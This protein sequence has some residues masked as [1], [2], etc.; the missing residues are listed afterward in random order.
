MTDQDALEEI[1]KHGDILERHMYSHGAFAT[2]FSIYPI[3]WATY[4]L[5][6]RR[7]ASLA[8]TS[9]EWQRF[10]EF[11]YTAIVRC[12]NT[13]RTVNRFSDTSASNISEFDP[14][15]AQLD[16]HDAFACFFYFVGAAVDNL[17]QA[18]AS[19]PVRCNTAF[20]SIFG[21]AVHS[22]RN[23]DWFFKRRH[24]FI[25]KALVPCVEESELISVDVSFFDEVETEWDKP[26]P[27]TK[28]EDAVG[29]LDSLWNQFTTEMNAAWSKLLEML[30]R[31]PPGPSPNHEVA[32]EAL[33]HSSGNIHHPGG[34]PSAPAD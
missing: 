34:P 33:P 24:Q 9:D 14:A 28:L 19:P 2:R 26:R 1:Q 15:K 23:L 20:E 13:M 16:F 18:F 30:K 29:L 3:I 32:S 22:G 5:P 6:E 31:V 4:L 11:H 17:G 7:R 8:L 10:A 21:H 12:W 27:T 25:H